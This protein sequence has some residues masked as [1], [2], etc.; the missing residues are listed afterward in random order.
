MDAAMR[1]SGIDIIGVVPWGT[2]LCQFYDTCQDLI[3][4][5]VPYFREGLKA[6][7][8]CMWIVSAPL[9]VDSAVNALRSE[10]PDLDDYIEK[11]QIEILDYSQWYTRSGKF[12]ANEVLNGWVNKLKAALERGYA[13]LR[14]SGNTFWLEKDDWENFTQIRGGY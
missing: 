4:I 10:V 6:G 11:G 9:Q 13:G 2:H 3:E 14:L 7:E 12:S 1:Q 8:F 5:L